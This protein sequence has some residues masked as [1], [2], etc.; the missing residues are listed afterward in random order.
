MTI[1]LFYYCTLIGVDRKKLI[2]LIIR[3]L[4]F[5]N[6]FHDSLVNSSEIS[7]WKLQL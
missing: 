6:G 5:R 2:P 3:L 1:L 7:K 4:E